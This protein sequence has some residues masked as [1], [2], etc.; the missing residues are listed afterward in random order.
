VNALDLKLVRDLSRSRGQVISIALVVAA[1]I[2]CA[3][4]MQST[5][6]S[7]VAA[8]DA[9]YAQYRFA[10]VFASL[11]RAPHTLGARLAAIPG[12][13]SAQTRIKLTVVL[14]VPGLDLPAQGLLVSVPE[15]GPPQVNGLH[16]VSG[17][18]LAPG[19]M[20]EVL[21]S[22]RFAQVNR[23]GAGD[24][25]RAVLNGRART[26]RVVGLALSPEYV[27]E[28][29]ASGG[30]IADERLFGVLWMAERVLAPASDLAGAFNDVA[31]LLA[32]GASEPDVMRR[33]DALLRAYGGLGAY[34]RAQQ[35]SHRVLSDEIR[36][37]MS[38]AHILPII[39][40][41]VSAFLLHIVLLRLTATQRT[42]IAVLKAFGYTNLRVGAHYLLYALAAGLLGAGMGVLAGAWLGSAYTR[43]YAEYFHFPEL[44]YQTDWQ[45]T[46]GAVL[47]SLAACLTGAAAAVRAAVRLQP[48]QAMRGS[49][50]ARFRRLLAERW[51]IQWLSVTQRMILRNLQR[52]PLR[53]LFATIGVGFA[54]AVLLVGLIMFDSVR[55]M[56]GLQFGVLQREDVTVAFVGTRPP[57]VRRELARLPGVIAAEEFLSVP[58]R[59]VHAH[60]SVLLPLTGLAAAGQL[61]VLRTAHGQTRPPPRDGIALTDR[62]ARKLGL[63][64]GAAVTIEVLERPGVEHTVRVRA[65]VDETVGINAYMELEALQRL[66][67]QAPVS[68]GALLR[69]DRAMESDLLRQLRDLP[70]VRGAVSK[71]ATLR[72]FD[73]QVA[74]SI[75]VT[76]TILTILSVIL[77]AG[78]IYNSAR[79]A[80]SERDLE[81]ATLRVLGFTNTEVANMLLGEQAIVTA[82]G[83]PLGWGIGCA[84]ALLI[85][86][87]FDTQLYHMPLEVSVGS[88]FLATL[89][90]AVIGVAAGFLVRRRLVRGDPVAVLKTRE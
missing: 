15:T 60:H 5:F 71:T 80:L 27:Y 50:P 85:L 69:V 18:Y 11:T 7:L 36:Q 8:R 19:A 45:V 35:P 1:G 47:L 57:R 77:G 6:R 48:A 75:R 84:V 62:L 22:V 73:Q 37:N 24:S 40:L 30:F 90:T 66:L 38:T 33:A 68:S 2:M 9:Y 72:N 43:L 4:T 12:V 82:M 86:S 81:L 23:L 76:L 89:S 49:P 25:L 74:R 87:S 32:P 67:R 46:A 39:F 64:A 10:H 61:R 58:I 16:L 56:I 41:S 54:L 13:L 28:T 52:R 17:R 70:G 29:A 83:I 78:I 34:N 42:Q 53:A 31:L 59:L 51:N 44:R 79:I 21:V 20:D 88:L 14:S 55:A 26:L 3:V 63:Q 65:L